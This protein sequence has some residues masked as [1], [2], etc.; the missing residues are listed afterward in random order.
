MPE[1]RSPGCKA[2]CPQNALAVTSQPSLALDL[3]DI[4]RPAAIVALATAGLLVW[5]LLTATP[6]QRRALAIVT[7]IAVLFLSLQIGYLLLT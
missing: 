5:R 2:L 4:H 1:R 7:P 3:T 6:P